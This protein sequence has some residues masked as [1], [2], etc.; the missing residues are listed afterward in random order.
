VETLHLVQSFG[1]IKIDI[2]NKV[3]SA[4]FGFDFF[5]AG[6]QKKCRN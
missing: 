6:T 2:G 4:F 5:V 3:D 1:G